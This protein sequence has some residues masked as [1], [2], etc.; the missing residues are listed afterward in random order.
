[1]KSLQRAAVALIVAGTS[2]VAAAPAHAVPAN[3]GVYVITPAWWGHCPG[4]GVAGLATVN[5]YVGHSQPGDYGDDVAW[6]PVRLNTTQSVQI[7]VA[8]KRFGFVTGASISARITPR[9]NG[10][11]FFFGPDSSFWSN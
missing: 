11:S 4:T 2:A 1:M 5:S 6:M 10:Q 3:G 8:C 7:K 9:R